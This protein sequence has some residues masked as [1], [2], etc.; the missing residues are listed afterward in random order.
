MRIGKAR[1]LRRSISVGVAG[2]LVAAL[3]AC[4]GRGG[5]YLP[6]TSPT[7]NGPASF[8]FDFSCEDKG[9][10]NPR[11][12]QL[13][14]Q[15]GYVE[16]GTYLATGLPFSVHGIVDVID[17]VVESA[18]C[19]GQNP[20]PGGSTLIF[21]GRYW[22]ASTAPVDFPTSCPVRDSQKTPSCRFEIQ[23]KDND[24]NLAPS[25]GDYFSI[26]LSSTTA[27]G[28]QLDPGT[29]FYTRAGILEGGNVAVD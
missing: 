1:L 19:I 22:P 26:Q 4:T 23:V 27:L 28:S 2:I 15:V 16:H 21:L 14:I 13:V 17:P 20:P 5:G 24:S 3:A 11:T 8:G 9:G 10:L 29:V 6:A 18:I 25:T 7:F 12:G